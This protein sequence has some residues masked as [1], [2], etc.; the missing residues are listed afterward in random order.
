[1]SES[2]NEKICLSDDYNSAPEITEKIELR[3]HGVDMRPAIET[4][5]LNAET[6]TITA[7]TDIINQELSKHNKPEL[8]SF[9][10]YPAGYHKYY[11]K[12]CEYVSSLPKGTQIDA[13]DV[14]E[15]LNIKIK[16]V[17]PLLRW[18]LEHENELIV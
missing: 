7:S 9:I 11:S 8:S 4:I 13:F 17:A 1:M 2:D 15:A 18:I 10:V 3:I 16:Y 5:D 6:F 14:S 12:I